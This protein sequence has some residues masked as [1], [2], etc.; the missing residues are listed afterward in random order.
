MPPCERAESYL[1]F[2]E[3]EPRTMNDQLKDYRLMLALPQYGGVCNSIFAQG[4]AD[5]AYIAGL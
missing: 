3:D 1:F 5:L 2:A 4:L